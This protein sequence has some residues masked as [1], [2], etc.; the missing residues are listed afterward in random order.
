MGLSLQRPE[1]QNQGGSWLT[2]LEL[3][4]RRIYI[5]CFRCL[6][7]LNEITCNDD[8]MILRKDLVLVVNCCRTSLI[9]F[10]NEVRFTVWLSVT[11]VRECFPPPRQPQDSAG[12][13]TVQVSCGHKPVVWYF[14]RNIQLPI[15]SHLCF[16][17]SNWLLMDYKTI[18]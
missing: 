16:C 6:R 8:H 13:C 17:Y 9:T 1:R 4:P 3:G 15:S 12:V 7:Q 14:L 5:R 18:L 10:W 2:F 11:A